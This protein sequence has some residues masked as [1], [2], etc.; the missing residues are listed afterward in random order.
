MAM[1]TKQSLDLAPSQPVR[2]RRP[3]SRFHMVFTAFMAI[4][5]RDIVVTGRQIFGFLLQELMQSLFFLFIFGRIL[6]AIGMTQ[7]YFGALFLPGIIALTVMLSSI[8][9]VALPLVLDLG[10]AHEIDDRLL[11][12]LPVSLVAVEKILFA[13]MRGL[14]AGAIMFPLAYWILGSAY[15]VRS[16]EI[17]IITGVMV[18]TAFASAGLGLTIG[19]LVHSEYMGLLFSMIFAP[20]IFTGCTYYP[21]TALS[22]V[23]WF[24]IVTLFNPLTY[25]AEGLRYAMV[26]PLNG[27]PLATLSPVW[28]ILGLSVTLVIFL[29][30]GML[31]FRRRVLG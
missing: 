29:T 28:V 17:A 27:H 25:A 3:A 9:A 31:S 11:A 18:L 24:Q 5:Y 19:T 1:I 4:L 2:V 6:P 21:W 22:G 8:Q 14:F 16:D 10:Y 15:Q 12:P 13:A 30:T 20:L 7:P 23:R 26:P